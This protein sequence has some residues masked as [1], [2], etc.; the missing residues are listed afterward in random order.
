MSFTCEMNGFKDLTVNFIPGAKPELVC[1]AGDDEVERVDLQSMKTAEL[2][3][4]MKDRGATCLERDDI[5]YLATASSNRFEKRLHKSGLDW[6]SRGGRD[7]LAKEP[8]SMGCS[9]SSGKQKVEV[10]AE[11]RRL[12]V[13]IVENEEAAE[14]IDVREEDRG[15][16]SALDNETVLQLLEGKNIKAGRRMSIG[17][18]LDA[19]KEA[20]A[21]KAIQQLGDAIEPARVPRR[22]VR[23]SSILASLHRGRRTFRIH[24]QWPRPSPTFR[25]LAGCCARSARAARVCP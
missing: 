3:Q 20:F 24:L 4:L 17:T 5:Q 23:V 2:H 9:G 22:L 15:L 1:F 10:P 8:I 21:N 7:S 19:G 11:R 12:S 18:A 25:L 6:K 14:E 13:G 16:L